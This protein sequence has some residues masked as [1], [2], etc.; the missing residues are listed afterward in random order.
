MNTI[1]EKKKIDDYNK[2]LKAKIENSSLDELF[3]H[4]DLLK[5]ILN[6]YQHLSERGDKK[7]DKDREKDI[8]RTIHD[9]DM[10]ILDKQGVEIQ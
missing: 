9:I 4:R 1:E 6:T 2:N 8:L 5:A 3:F 7:A 10:A